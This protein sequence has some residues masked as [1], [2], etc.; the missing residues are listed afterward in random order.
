MQPSKNDHA[1]LSCCEAKAIV[2]G[3]CS[4][5]YSRLRY[6]ELAQSAGEEPQ[7]ETQPEIPI[8]RQPSRHN[9][10]YCGRCSCVMHKDGLTYESS[11]TYMR[12]RLMQ[13]YRCA[14]CGFSLSSTP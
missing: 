4:R 1:C 9:F 6:Q 14:N 10:K 12:K 13:T 5:C 2:T 7:P 3:L 11:S 8:P